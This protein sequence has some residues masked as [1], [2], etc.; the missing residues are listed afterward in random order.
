MEGRENAPNTQK[1]PVMSTEMNNLAEIAARFLIQQYGSKEAAT[2]AIQEGIECGD[3]SVARAGVIHAQE[4]FTKMA[5][6]A[7]ARPTQTAKMVYAQL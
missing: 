1:D 2:A 6:A 5:K 7:V 4:T 3:Y